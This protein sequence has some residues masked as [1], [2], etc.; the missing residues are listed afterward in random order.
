MLCESGLH[1]S[2]KP[3]DALKYAPGN[4]L[5]RVELAGEILEEADKC[6]AARRRIIWRFNAESL[7]REFAR[8]CAIQVIDEWDAPDV[9]KR[10]LE[11]GD[12]SL[13]EEA[14]VASVAASYA[15]HAAY[16]ASHASSASAYAAYASYASSAYASYASYASAAVYNAY[17]VYDDNARKK[18]NKKFEEMINATKKQTTS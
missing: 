11:I 3:L 8:W 14:R 7:L 6:V 17:A 2:V 18:Q 9:V 13:R 12:E 4:T 1:A 5:C 10:Y 15:S 16:A